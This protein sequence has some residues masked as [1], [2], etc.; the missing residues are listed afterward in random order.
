[1]AE[2]LSKFFTTGLLYAGNKPSNCKK[3]QAI[4][5]LAKAAPQWHR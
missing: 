5:G 3:I 1:M 4:Q 2:G